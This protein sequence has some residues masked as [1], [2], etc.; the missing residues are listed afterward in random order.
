MRMGKS[1]SGNDGRVERKGERRIVRWELEV[2]VRMRSIGG[3]WRWTERKGWERESGG[4]GEKRLL[5]EREAR[6]L[7]L[8]WMHGRRGGSG[9]RLTLRLLRLRRI[10]VEVRKLLLYFLHGFFLPLLHRLDVLALRLTPLNLLLDIRQAL[11]EVVT[12]ASR[13]EGGVRN[14]VALRPGCLVRR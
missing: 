1:G 6:L 11:D 4:G 12:P 2:G 9:R 7:D 13:E 8:S 5:L 14:V 10:E 3:K